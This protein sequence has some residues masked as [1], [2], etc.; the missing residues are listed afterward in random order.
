MLVSLKKK[1][2]GTPCLFFF[3]LTANNHNQS[4][5]L[6][7]TY[8]PVQPATRPVVLR[9]QPKFSWYQAFLAAGLLLGFGASATVFVKVF[10]S[11]TNLF[12]CFETFGLAIQS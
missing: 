2:K 12:A 4:T 8:K 11:F 9:A 7:Q 1:A 6:L 3:L 10:F 5:G